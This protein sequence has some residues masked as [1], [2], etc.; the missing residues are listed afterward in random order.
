MDPESRDEVHS[1]GNA[2]R[3]TIVL[4]GAKYCRN[5]RKKA[6]VDQVQRSVKRPLDAAVN[7]VAPITLKSETTRN[8]SEHR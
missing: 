3:R 4:I 8:D 7:A 5:T 2:D 1:P 6:K